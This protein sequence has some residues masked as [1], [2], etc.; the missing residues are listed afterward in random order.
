MMMMMMIRR[1]RRRRR[2]RLTK[3]GRENSNLIDFV[4]RG[5]TLQCCQYLHYIEMNGK[6]GEYWKGSGRK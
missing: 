2:R 3:T 4:G 5:F 6:S 1:R